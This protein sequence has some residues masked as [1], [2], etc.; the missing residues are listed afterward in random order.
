MCGGNSTVGSNPTA[1][2]TL[3]ASTARISAESGP[4]GLPPSTNGSAKAAPALRHVRGVEAPRV[5]AE[6][7]R[8]GYTAQWWKLDVAVT[9]VGPKGPRLGEA[10]PEGRL[11]P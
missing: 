2:A 1:T 5:S 7:T 6:A 10:G 9:Q 4:I 3:R 11:Y 8:L